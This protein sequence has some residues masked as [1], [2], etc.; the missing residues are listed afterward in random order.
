MRAGIMTLMF[1]RR[2]QLSYLFDLGFQ[3]WLTHCFVVSFTFLTQDTSLFAMQVWLATMLSLSLALAF[4]CRYIAG[5]NAISA[6]RLRSAGWVHT[7]LT[8]IVGITWGA[9]AIWVSHGSFDSLLIFT[10]ALGGTALGAV[11]AQH[12]VMRSCLASIWTSVPLLAFAHLAHPDPVT[13]KA[14]AAMML[15]YGLVLTFLAFRM[16]RF[17][18]ANKL[19]SEDLKKRIR[20]VTRISNAYQR[21]HQRAEEANLAKSRFLAHA[22]HD[23]RQPV[24]AIGMLAANL[25]EARLTREQRTMVED[26]D[27]SVS[28]LS[29]LFRS[30]LDL[31]ALDVGKIVARPIPVELGPLLEQVANANRGAAQKSGCELRLVD[32][33]LW[34]ETDPNL[35]ASMIQNLINNAIKYAPGESILVGCLLRG[36]VV[37]VCVIDQGRGIG[38]D[39]RDLVFSEFYRAKRTNEQHVEGLGL[40]LSIVNR[41]AELLSLSCVLRSQPE[42]GTWVEISGLQSTEQRDAKQSKKAPSL[43]RLS[44]LKVH[45]VENDVD[46]LRA[47]VGLLERWGCSVSESSSIPNG[48][49]GCELLLTDYALENGKNGLDCVNDVR[50]LEGWNVPAVIV[51]GVAG[52]DFEKDEQIISLEK[53]VHAARLRAAITSLTLQ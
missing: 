39:E 13:G 40:G 2:W 53:P 43:H 34:V 33:S 24:H 32:S 42:Y 46:T 38:T 1:P 12:S 25:H 28:A 29:R 49:G 8:T 10:L 11:S 20:Q 50:T 26:I 44:G 45:V 19:L 52:L 9:G 48:A 5:S 15:L 51:T 31:S 22:S 4:L 16:W 21:E 27:R 37:S 14:N 41:F 36:D 30:L 3:G 35:L 17:L 7:I 18:I 23:L 47:T 6:S